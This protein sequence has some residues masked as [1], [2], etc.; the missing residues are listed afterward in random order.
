M[1]FVNNHNHEMVVCRV[2]D[3]IKALDKHEEEYFAPHKMGRAWVTRRKPKNG[4]SGAAGHQ[5]KAQ[6]A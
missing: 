3:L 6:K 1:A 4:G 5:R 2:S